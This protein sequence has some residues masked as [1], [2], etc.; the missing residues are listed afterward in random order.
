MDELET[1]TPVEIPYDR[2]LTNRS[3]AFWVSSTDGV[4]VSEGARDVYPRTPLEKA[5]V[6]HTP[7]TL[8][9]D[10]GD[11]SVSRIVSGGALETHVSG[12]VGAV[13]FWV[14]GTPCDGA[15]MQSYSFTITHGDGKTIFLMR[16]S[17]GEQISQSV[18]TTHILN[19]VWNFVQLRWSSVTINGIRIDEP[20]SWTSEVFY[21]P[22]DITLDA[23]IEFTLQP[24]TPPDWQVPVTWIDTQ[25]KSYDVALNT[26]T[27]VIQIL[28][29]HV[30]SQ[31]VPLVTCPGTFGIRYVNNNLEIFVDTLGSYNSAPGVF[32]TDGVF[33]VPVS[34]QNG[35]EWTRVSMRSTE[36]TVSVFLDAVA[37][38]TY[39]S[40]VDWVPGG[41]IFANTASRDS[42]VTG[43]WFG[44][45]AVWYSVEHTDDPQHLSMWDLR[46][47][48]HETTTLHEAYPGLMYKDRVSSN[49]WEL[50]R[51]GNALR[52]ITLDSTTSVLV[53][54]EDSDFNH[55]VITASEHGFDVYVDGLKVSTVTVPFFPSDSLTLNGTRLHN[56]H[57]RTHEPPRKEVCVKYFGALV[58][59]I[60]KFMDVTVWSAPDPKALIT[61]DASVVLLMENTTGYVLDVDHLA[62]APGQCAVVRRPNQVRKMEA[63]FESGASHFPMYVDVDRVY[64]EGQDI[65][66]LVRGGVWT[67]DKAPCTAVRN[68]AGSPL[69][70]YGKCD[71]DF[72]PEAFLLLGH[73]NFRAYMDVT[74]TYG[75]P[76]ELSVELTS[77]NK[78]KLSADTLGRDYEISIPGVIVDTYYL[79]PRFHITDGDR[80]NVRSQWGEVF[81]LP[82]GISHDLEALS[83]TLV[84]ESDIV[85]GPDMG[86]YTPPVEK[87]YRDMVVVDGA[88]SDSDIQRL[89]SGTARSY[90]GEDK[91]FRA[92]VYSIDTDY[93]W[94]GTTAFVSS[95]SVLRPGEFN[96][97]D[98]DM[99]VPPNV[100]SVVI[101]FDCDTPVEVGSVRVSKLSGDANS[102]VLAAY[103]PETSDE[104]YSSVKHGIFQTIDM[105]EN[106]TYAIDASG[107]SGDLFISTSPVEDQRFLP[108]SIYPSQSNT[109]LRYDNEPVHASSVAK[110]G[111]IFTVPFNTAKS[112]STLYYRTPGGVS[113][114]FRIHPSI[115]HEGWNFP[116][117]E[118]PFENSQLPPV[119]YRRVN[120]TV[121][122]VGRFEIPRGSI[123]SPTILFVLET[124]YR[125]RSMF[126][127]SLM[128]ESSF[129]LLHCRI[130]TEGVVEL[131]PTGSTLIIQGSVSFV[132]A[133]YPVSPIGSAPTV[134]ETT[135]VKKEIDVTSSFDFDIDIF[136]TS[137]AQTY[138]ETLAAAAG[139][140][141]S[142]VRL[143]V[144]EGS[145]IVR[146]RIQQV[147]SEV[148]GALTDEMT[149]DFDVLLQTY[150]ASPASATLLSDLGPSV[151]KSVSTRDVS[152]NVTFTEDVATVRYTNVSD[153]N[154][155][156]VETT[157]IS[158]TGTVYKVPNPGS[159]ESSVNWFEQGLHPPW[160]FTIQ[161]FNSV[162]SSDIKMTE[163]FGPSE[164]ASVNN[165]L[166]VKW[167]DYGVDVGWEEPEGNGLDVR[168]YVIHHG[169]M[170][171]H[172][173]KPEI[174]LSWSSLPVALKIDTHTRWNTV[175]E[176]PTEGELITLVSPVLHKEVTEIETTTT[177]YTYR[178]VASCQ[179]LLVNMEVAL[180]N[181]RE[182]VTST[183]LSTRGMYIDQ[184]RTVTV[185]PDT[186]YRVTH[187]S[188]S[189]VDNN[190]AVD[191]EFHTPDFEWSEYGSLQYAFVCDD[192]GTYVQ[193]DLCIPD[194][195]GSN[196]N[197]VFNKPCDVDTWVH[198]L[199]CIA[200]Q[201]PDESTKP[202]QVRFY[203]KLN[204]EDAYTLITTV[205]EVMY[206]PNLAPWGAAGVEAPPT[207][208]VTP[209]H[210]KAGG[211][212][213]YVRV[214][215]DTTGKTRFAW[216]CNYRRKHASTT[217]VIPRMVYFDVRETQMLVSF[218][219]SR[220]SLR[221]FL[222]DEEM[223][224]LEST[225][226]QAV[227]DGL[228]YG[229]HTLRYESV[230]PDNGSVTGGDSHSFQHTFYPPASFTP[231][232]MASQDTQ[233]FYVHAYTIP[234]MTRMVS[235]GFWSSADILFST[236]DNGG[237]HW[238]PEVY[239]VDVYGEP[240]RRDAPRTVTGS[241]EIVGWAWDGFPI[242]DTDGPVDIC[243]GNYVNMAKYNQE[244]VYAY[245]GRVD[246]FRAYPILSSSN[247]V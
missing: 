239:G 156:R 195:T 230:S 62:V 141:V 182:G 133:W 143:T 4:H 50:E 126:Y 63:R 158:H 241:G 111:I 209:I 124:A 210:T 177:A 29:E 112:F 214:E 58:P 116:D 224:L 188:S 5:H 151:V 197:R 164:P 117:I 154:V 142:F 229:P 19:G 115:F 104:P 42:A 237:G 120:D 155:G 8:S 233:N 24:I 25:T 69:R 219:W 110:S 204:L 89:V 201:G 35:N 172:S 217:D 97:L 81:D 31:N 149:N 174:R 18:D 48:T 125:P 66:F 129:E 243:G 161:M 238:V 83:L 107:C 92:R 1:T 145:V 2:E 12:Y 82:Y 73:Q 152:A 232:G 176:R 153:L 55:I 136:N 166:S 52:I 181:T 146:A 147:A 74:R 187:T 168:R 76:S 212:Y 87:R 144:S 225:L 101:E 72:S 206:D 93:Q 20:N 220:G 61:W 134:Y 180:T 10:W 54:E 68:Q 90:N 157:L 91:T 11:R 105:F 108:S 159:T 102:S 28:F 138:R 113:G 98:Y 150:A 221:W 245:L 191:Y 192:V 194:G 199:L 127:G 170:E 247:F 51:D 103:I 30:A 122:I 65:E 67:R 171:L 71:G 244:G 218:E 190:Q 77:T 222:D 45:M 160:R 132:N 246:R 7:P 38:V 43:A 196:V 128:H 49:W 41:L 223:P 59:N 78:V 46:T 86:W 216:Q 184:T 231:L 203:G 200:I 240:I 130:G 163:P 53:H 95:E 179:G 40:R 193:T 64:P 109:L 32:Y 13:S 202:S 169:D 56:D 236:P 198:E 227:Y 183:D 207:G 27:Y 70:I 213:R 208:S 17:T 140:D 39:S 234:L 37:V 16:R 96:T 211:S 23:P 47:Y 79:E 15:W 186:T 99:D 85:M 228:S 165:V 121:S 94:D 123:T 100:T 88:L 60:T 189:L 131:L 137:Y 80:L 114:K 33:T 106:M 173:T 167:Y 139:V 21:R 175:F 36:E 3:L 162:G 44:G 185:D 215:V 148:A 26:N 205:D 118:A 119:A 75:N 14:M 34:H 242:V 6:Y 235:K 22:H 135:Q 226:Q 57:S 84:N 9:A 178:V